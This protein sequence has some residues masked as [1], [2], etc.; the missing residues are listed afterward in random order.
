MGCLVKK[1]PLTDPRT[2]TDPRKCFQGSHYKPASGYFAV[3]SFQ[4]GFMNANLHVSRIKHLSRKLTIW[5]P[6]KNNSTRS[7]M[8]GPDTHPP[9][10]LPFY[11][12]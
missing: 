12:L 11:G 5:L 10:A 1:G 2:P 6:A 7:I 9:P 4:K 8:E 3:K